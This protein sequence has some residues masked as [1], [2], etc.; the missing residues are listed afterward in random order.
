MHR[1]KEKDSCD[2]WGI[3]VVLLCLTILPFEI[4]Y[5]IH[6]SY[7][8][9]RDWNDNAIM[10]KCMVNSSGIEEIKCDYNDHDKNFPCYNG[11]ITVEYRLEDKI[12]MGKVLAYEQINFRNDL[13][14]DLDENYPAGKVVH[15]YY[16]KRSP[17]QI[18]LNLYETINIAF[19]VCKY[20]G[21]FILAIVVLI[22]IINCRSN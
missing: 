2:K 13:V 3:V 5:L 10:T 21:Y 6:N 16:N 4:A 14:D 19:Y 8:F 17:D 12:Q 18:R 22:S 7:S 9:N 20:I 15:C 11:F 1:K